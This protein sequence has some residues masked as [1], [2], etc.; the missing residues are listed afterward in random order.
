MNNIK[1]KLLIVFLILF[2]VLSTAYISNAETEVV[3][4]EMIEESYGSHAGQ[5]GAESF[6]P[7]EDLDQYYDVL[8]SQK[9]AP[10]PGTMGLDEIGKKFPNIRP[11]D[12][13]T[14]TTEPLRSLIRSHA[15]ALYKRTGGGKNIATPKEAYILAEMKY[16]GGTEKDYIQLAWWTTQAAGHSSGSDGV[17]E[18][19]D[20]AGDKTRSELEALIDDV[21]KGNALAREATYFEAY[22]LKAANVNKVSELKHKTVT[23]ELAD[24]TRRE[25][26]GAF[27]ITYEPKWAT[28]G[29][30][31]NPQVRLD[32]GTFLAGPFALDY[33]DASTQQGDRPEVQF[34]G[35]TGMEIYVDSIDTPLVFGTDWEFVWVAG[36]REE[37]ETS[38]Y[39]LA[40]E[41]FY[42]RLHD[43]KDATK[44]VNIKT[45]FRY[46]NACG[47]YYVYEGDYAETEWKLVYDTKQITVGE[48]VLTI[49]TNFRMVLDKVQLV[50]AQKLTAGAHGARWYE[51]CT[52]DREV[53][54]PDK[55]KGNIT[56]TKNVIDEY[57]R[58]INDIIDENAKFNFKIEFNGVLEEKKV[59]NIE[60]KAGQ[61][62]SSLTYT[63]YK[64]QPVPTYT[65]T[66]TVPSEYEIVSISS[67][68]KEGTTTLEG[69]LIENSSVVVKA[70]NKKTK[71][72]G[73]LEIIKKIKDYDVPEVKKAC[74]GKEF[75][76]KVKISGKSFYY[77]GTEYGDK[78]P[79]AP[80]ELEIGVKAESSEFIRD[81]EWFG[82]VAPTYEVEEVLD[83]EGFVQVGEIEGR[84]GS[85]LPRESGSTTHATAIGTNRL[86]QEQGSIK[87]IKTVDL[88]QLIASLNLPTTV[89]I[90]ELLDSK[91]I[92]IDKILK[93]EFKFD[94]LIKKKID[95]SELEHKEVTLKDGVRTGT[96]VTW[97]KVVGTYRWYYGFNPDY[98]IKEIVPDGYTFE[99]FIDPDGNPSGNPVKGTI[100]ANQNGSITTINTAGNK[101][102]L[103]PVSGDI[104]ITKKIDNKVLEDAD[105]SFILT[106]TGQF[107]Y[108]GEG[109]KFGTYQISNVDENGNIMAS[110]ARIIEVI[111]GEPDGNAPVTIHVEKDKTEKSWTISGITWYKEFE[112]TPT[113]EIEES[114]LAADIDFAV[115][116]NKGELVAGGK[117]DIIAMNRTEA[118]LSKLKISKRVEYSEHF[119]TEY[120]NTLKFEFSVDVER[121]GKTTVILDKDNLTKVHNEETGKDELVWE[122]ETQDYNWNIN[123]GAPKYTIEEVAGGNGV[124]F[125]SAT[126]ETYDGDTVVTLTT[127]TNKIE[128][129]LIPNELASAE[130]KTTETAVINKV[131]IKKGNLKIIKDVTHKS[132]EGKEFTFNVTLTGHFKYK[133][134]WYDKLELKDDSAVIVKGGESKVVF[135]E[136]IEWYG[137]SGPDYL[138]EEVENDFSEKISESNTSGKL[139]DGKTATVTFVNGP[140]YVEGKLVIN[141]LISGNK[142]IGEDKTFT[143]ELK[144]AKN[145]QALSS[146]K[147]TYFELKPNGTHEVYQKWAKTEQ[148]PEYSVKEINLPEGVTLEKIDIVG[149][150]HKVD[151]YTVQGT[152]EKDTSI[153]VVYTN[154]YDEHSGAFRIVKQLLAEEKLLGDVEKKFTFDARIKGTFTIKNK[155]GEI[156]K[157][158]VNGTY[159]I[160]DIIIEFEP[161][162]MKASY[163]SNSEYE[164][165]WYGEDAPTVEVE[166]TN[167]CNPWKYVSTAN[168]GA[169]LKEDEIIEITVTNE[170][171][172]VTELL[173][174]IRL[175]GNVWEDIVLNP[176]AKNDP[177]YSFPN[178]FIDEEK[179]SGIEGIKVYIYDDSGE[180][181]T[182]YNNALKEV[183]EQPLVTTSN[184]YWNAPMIK[185]TKGKSG[186]YDQRYHAVFVYDGQTYEPTVFLA[187]SDKDT[188]EGKV[189]DY[190]ALSL[191]ENERTAEREKFFKNSMAL[192]VDRDA[193]N[194]RFSKIS[195]YSKISDEGI[196][197]GIA[198]NGEE[199][200]M[201]FYDSYTDSNNRLASK[202]RT[203][204]EET[205]DIYKVFENNA[206]TAVANIEYPFDDRAILY[207]MDECIT[208]VYK[209]TYYYS[210]TYDYCLHVNLGLKRRKDVDISVL[211]D[212]VSANVVIRDQVHDYQFNRYEDLISRVEDGS[213]S[214]P[215][216][217]EAD[218]VSYKLGLYATDYYYRAEMYEAD[219]TVYDSLV[220]MYKEINKNI[221][222][223]EMDVYLNYK[224]TVFNESP[225]D[226]YKV[227]INSLNDYFDSTFGSPITERIEKSGKVLADVS[228]YAVSTGETGSVEWSNIID[229][230]IEGSDG[231]KYNKINTTSLEDVDVRNGQKVDIYVSFKI[232]KEQF[233]GV[234]DAVSLGNKA[235]IAEIDS[236]SVY[237]IVSGANVGKIDMDS[238]PD[239][240]N[241][242]SHNSKDW[243]EDDTYDSPIL[244]LQLENI[245]R[246]LSGLSWEDNGDGK[247]DADEALIGGLTTELVEKVSANGKEYDFLWPTDKHI[248]D[249]GG[250]TFEELTGFKSITETSINSGE[251]GKYK[252]VGI[253]EGKYVVRFLYGNNKLDLDDKYV[254]RDNAT[255][256]KSDG[257]R[258]SSSTLT[259][260][261]SGSGVAVYNGQDYKSTIYQKDISENIDSSTGYVINKNHNLKNVELATGRLSDAR[262]SEVRRLQVIAESEI[263]KNSISEIL[264]TAN[265][266][267]G[268]HNE[269]FELTNMYAD[270]A[271][272]DITNDNLKDSAIEAVERNPE[273]ESAGISGVQINRNI[274]TYKVNN[275]DFALE[276]RPKTKVVIDK[277]IK[278]IKL[279]TNDGKM[280]FNAIYDINYEFIPGNT[281]PANKTVIGKVKNGTNI[282]YLVAEVK[283]SN[284]S[285]GTEV[286]QA[287]NKVESKNNNIQNFRFVNIDTDILQGATVEI[288]YVITA[289]NIGETDYT[290]ATLANLTEEPDKTIRAKIY[291]LASQKARTE[292]ENANP[293]IGEFVGTNYYTGIIGSDVVVTTRVRQLVDYVD[294]NAIFDQNI[295]GEKNHSWRNTTTT[296]LKGNG[297]KSEVLVG[298]DVLPEYDITD[299]EGVAY[300]SNSKDNII[301]SI[302][303]L[304]GQNSEFE[305]KLVPYNVDNN[306][307]KSQI[308]LT[309]TKIVGSQDD[310]SAMSFDNIAE[311]VKIENSVGR[312]DVKSV[313]GNAN[314]RGMLISATVYEDSGAI[315]AEARVMKGE[316]YAALAETD[317]SATE[318]VTFTPPTGQD[319]N[320]VITTEVLIAIIA[321][322]VLMIVGT[323][324]IKKKA[325]K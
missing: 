154:R 314:P 300:I 32:N 310:T 34:A 141:K 291:D 179:E 90:E 210:A 281:E 193:F 282:G 155:N 95:G 202:V 93:Q 188:I 177:Y 283:L 191:N 236:Y 176:D 137:N 5:Y 83:V 309:V 240:I 315:R 231:A 46:M 4:G 212:L 161:N 197:K 44:I 145:G 11:A 115:A 307:Y 33:I 86:K 14:E 125:G 121:F 312:R 60:L 289:L 304:D 230:E 245:D 35:I 3:K 241:M 322:L 182:I 215:L 263:I 168:N 267:Y 102:N 180:Q 160:T 109:Y 249:L 157:T 97:H 126:Y 27:D 117:V 132:L 284:K 303:S 10:L 85:I 306:N 65:I 290:S 61:T 162:T 286:L 80:L 39:P 248:D 41:K 114:L 107:R 64:N 19:L 163:D 118:R 208:D 63:W 9:G 82:K 186:K 173:F 47:E 49:P 265:E 134:V 28:D 298:E 22:V 239:N 317:A 159:E 262:D 129:V 21:L 111:N 87:I 316:F 272:L 142:A 167:A 258:F 175:A 247:Y 18:I 166:E 311:I 101:L 59:E 250:K 20:A 184:G 37:G 320:S 242:R 220:D 69:N 130:F 74:E 113:F 269:L 227:R 190:K 152:F 150:G 206:S 229:S 224:I 271:I 200:N 246:E 42:I 323:I 280:I 23:I 31:A 89:S 58:N 124:Q 256:L 219:S 68:D 148:A 232:S 158:V 103:N 195:G 77:Q 275:I 278:S 198:E 183:I 99:G 285:I 324:V 302:D 71:T 16:G 216:N 88:A 106:L 279:T 67:G 218:K 299:S 138:V 50:P 62:K 287:I 234:F 237:N 120:L 225:T 112:S 201:L 252:F 259:A 313:T 105:Y 319:T 52:L 133:N 79:L 181:A 235:N 266:I 100:R 98:E 43:I 189:S 270:T 119:T 30:Y 254:T 211:K 153:S 110:G 222:S 276:E 131:N 1:S 170:I 156:L 8:C 116:P 221:D 264:N 12:K 203:I 91:A 146:V 92:D 24:G 104:V 25:F 54:V 318:L 273:N 243:Y 209:E 2:A 15:L 251:V 296:E 171:Q 56:I 253:P 53:G 75:K 204:D 147:P 238:A 301:L 174:T 6:I 292:A 36:E 196:T 48:T 226:E 139:E 260:N 29:E 122:G 72:I 214:R 228:S 288:N 223:T 17:K 38:Q 257:S 205:G 194:R 123:D 7:F 185:L 217:E 55:V 178:G 325:L 76:F 73:D 135:E 277:Q 81:I 308:E 13:G 213:Y 45:S 96:I 149:N 66:E 70:V 255:A 128:G 26:E 294:N 187:Q 165:I 164:I 192:D 151:D 84:Q 297:L 51:Y 207:D 108:N 144:I 127:D 233:N 172:K 136:D 261:Y 140:I 169:S 94:V 321:A 143:F 305:A 40:N 199:K 293:A 295:N 78:A 268:N 274:T 57:G 244:K